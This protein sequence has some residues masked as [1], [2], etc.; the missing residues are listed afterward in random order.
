MPGGEEPS[1]LDKVFWLDEALTKGDLIGYVDA[2]ADLILP[3]LRDR[4][5]TVIR[6]PNGVEGAS[7][8]QKDTPSYAPE[9]VRTVTLPAYGAK[10]DVRYTVCNDERTLRWLANQAAIEF[11]PWLS[12]T[13]RLDRPT[14]LVLDIDPPA[15]EDGFSRSVEVALLARDTLREA[16][17][18]GAAKTSGSKGV[19]IYVP[20]RRRHTFEEVRNASTRLAERVVA[21]APDL[22]TI[23]FKKAERGGRVFLD[24]TRN[25]PGAHIAAAYSPR[26]RPGAPVSF[27]VPWD[28]LD[29][30][31]PLDFTI[32]SAPWLVTERGDLWASLM[33]PPQALPRS[34]SD[35]G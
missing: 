2:L 8:Y 12:R 6:F 15:D 19:H 31:S 10:K 4:P 24:T 5:L 3:G 26:A 28:E 20:L 25:A 32:R 18:D 16:G 17:L 14:H 7:F 27:P 21:A 35:P 1:N 22:V 13:D 33:P 9:W 30:V 29:A 11:H 23:A 34:L